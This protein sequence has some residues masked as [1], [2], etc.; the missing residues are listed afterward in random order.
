VGKYLT[1]RNPSYIPSGD[2]IFAK[3]MV[4]F[5]F[6]LI[7]SSLS[8]FFYH[9]Q[10]PLL[11]ILAMRYFL[12]FLIFFCLLSLGY[13]KEYIVKTVIVFAVFYMVVFTIQLLVF[14]T[15]IVPL[16]HTDTFDRGF[17]R[18][19]L[20]GVGFITLTAFYSLNRYMETKRKIFII[21]YL[22]CFTFVFILGFRTL[23]ATFLFSSLLLVFWYE[24]TVVK[25]LLML[26][27]VLILA[28]IASQI[29]AIY[30]YL[31]SI[32]DK[33][34]EQYEQGLDYIRYLAFDFLFVDVNVDLGS[35][36]FGNGMPFEG[37]DYGNYV[38]GVGAK[39][40][41]YISADLGLIGF[42]F[43]YGVIGVVAFLNIYRIAIFTKL[44][45]DSIYLNVFF[46][47]LVISSFTTSEI[48]RSGMFGVQMLGLYL[49][50]VTCFEMKK[51][52][53]VKKVYIGT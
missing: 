39:N 22:T 46:I 6:A 23:L 49:V 18:L 42:A 35:L 5:G 31:E 45:K 52:G 51:V 40:L 43:N 44:P 28:M 33:S 15:A 26:G 4:Y 25:K 29:G 34:N 27:V 47:Y 36:I 50:V 3:P 9:D 2:F 13:S 30:E 41:G 8:G 7:V 19:R 16:G 32:F 38:L 1:G 14:P 17:L 37:T 48:Y 12:Y 53:G 20:E 11:T 21:L 10:N 24:R